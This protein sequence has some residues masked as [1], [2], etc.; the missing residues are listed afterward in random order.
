MQIKQSM[1]S[2]LQNIESQLTKNIPRHNK[3]HRRRH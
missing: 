3:S 2:N 1:A